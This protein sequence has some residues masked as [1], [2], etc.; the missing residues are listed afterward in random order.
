MHVGVNFSAVLQIAA[1]LVNSPVLVL[2]KGKTVWWFGCVA[3]N[4]VLEKGALQI[5]ESFIGK[6][7]KSEL[8]KVV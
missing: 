4:Y 3:H 5:A 1:K 7:Y 6:D 8:K 2:Q